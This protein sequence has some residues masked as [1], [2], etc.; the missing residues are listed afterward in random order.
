MG[1]TPALTLLPKAFKPLNLYLRWGRGVVALAVFKW[2]KPRWNAKPRY[3][4]VSTGCALLSVLGSETQVEPT[5]SVKWMKRIQCVYLKC[6]YTP[7]TTVT[8]NSYQQAEGWE[9]ILTGAVHRSQ[10]TAQSPE[11][12]PDRSDQRQNELHISELSELLTWIFLEVTI[13]KKICL[14][15]LFSCPETLL[16]APLKL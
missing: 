12:N 4:R 10:E 9:V 6:A 11:M 1:V 2:V 15:F 16:C 3:F 7:T 8:H 14:L 5:L 13:L